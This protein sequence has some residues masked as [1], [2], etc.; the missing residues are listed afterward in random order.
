[1]F[2]WAGKRKIN[3]IYAKL[4]QTGFM[5]SRICFGALTIGPLQANL[6]L[7]EGAQVIKTALELGIN[8]IDTA[9]MYK[10]YDYIREGLKGCRQDVIIATKSYAYNKE[11]AEKSLEKAR[12]EMNRDRIDIFMLHEQESYLTIKGHWEA[13]E[14]LWNAKD[15][16]IIGA[17]GISTHTVAAVQAAAEIKEI[18]VIHPMLNIRGLGIVDGTVDQMLAAIAQAKEAGKGIYTMK[19]IGGGNLLGNV[20]EALNWVFRQKGVDAVAIGMK[21]PEEVRIN[22]AWLLG[23][24]P[25]KKDLAKVSLEPRRL[26]IDRWCEGCGRCVDVCSQKALS[27]FKG[28]AV[29]DQESCLLCGYCGAACREFNIKIV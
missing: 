3:M 10:N 23:E 25:N 8:F 5:V 24:A 11:L 22:T 4:G 20:Q 9:E 6:S 28:K 7:A 29:V 2:F 1:L 18:D 12:R 13:L 15:K 21:S 27:L 19:A 16:G 17:V 14:Y 26:L